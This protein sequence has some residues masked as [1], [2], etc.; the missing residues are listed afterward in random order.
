M[1]MGPAVGRR[2]KST[3][4]GAQ[5][6]PLEHIPGM[7]GPQGGLKRNNS[8]PQ[9]QLPEIGGLRNDGN[10]ERGDSRSQRLVSARANKHNQL[11]PINQAIL[12]VSPTPQQNLASMS[13]N[14]IQ[15]IYD[16]IDRKSVKNRE[17]MQQDLTRIY[18]M[19]VNNKESGGGGGGNPP[20]MQMAGGP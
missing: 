15:H 20:G 4:R 5:I 9:L 10:A 2:H 18:M 14:K 3:V 8:K 13:P 11:S 7:Q 16:V 1:A 12:G 19:Q 17:K 6:Q